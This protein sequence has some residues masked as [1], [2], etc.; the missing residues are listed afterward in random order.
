MPGRR[1]GWEGYRG[2]CQNNNFLLGYVYFN[3][4]NYN[5]VLFYAYLMLLNDGLLL[6]YGNCLFI[7]IDYFLFMLINVLFELKFVVNCLG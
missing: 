5:L 7:Y 3:V 6:F 1:F 2:L 4:L